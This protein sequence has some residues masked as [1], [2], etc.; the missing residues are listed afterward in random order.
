MSEV[1]EEKNNF[2]IFD[3]VNKSVN[4]VQV[5][6]DISF[7]FKKKGVHGILAPKG[8]GKTE[9]LD[10]IASVSFADSGLISLDG[11]KIINS[12]DKDV[13]ASKMKVGYVRANTEFYGDMTVMETL[14]FVGETRKVKSDKLNR[15]IKEALELVGL[16]DIKQRLVKLLSFGEQ[17]KLSLACAL[18]GNPDVILIDEPDVSEMG[19]KRQ[20]DELFDLIRMLGK[21]KTVIITTQD[22]KTAKALCGD[23]VILSD[24]KV[25][26]NGTFEE[27]EAK[28]DGQASLEALYNSLLSTSK[29]GRDKK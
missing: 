25:L 27:L 3:E 13:K 14:S 20:D 5:L 8:S 29:K 21:P 7:D 16:Y 4:D 23:I 9:I 10:L 28:L 24:G 19:Y 18:L 22:F 26:A 11:R 15:Q 2:L 17:K 12:S 6:Y 1:F